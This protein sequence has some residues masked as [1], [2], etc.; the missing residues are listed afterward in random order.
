MRASLILSRIAL[1]IFGPMMIFSVYLYWRGHQVE[2]GGFIGGLVAAAAFAVVAFGFGIH[3]L[4]RRLYFAPVMYLAMGLTCTYGAGVLAWIA[5]REFLTG[6][7]TEIPVVGMVGTAL[8]FDL[9]VYLV[10]VG[11][12]TLILSEVMTD[13]GQE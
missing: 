9:G 13:G 2:G 4:K 7:W 6:L 3:E 11:M 12:I 1:W 10:V 5:G 8:L